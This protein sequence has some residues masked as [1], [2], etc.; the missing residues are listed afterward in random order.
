MS[1]IETGVARVLGAHGWQS[2]ALQVAVF[3]L[4]SAAVF[5]LELRPAHQVNL[6]LQRQIGRRENLL[7]SQVLK[8]MHT[9]DEDSM[10]LLQ[11]NR[12]QQLTDDPGAFTSFMDDGAGHIAW[13]SHTEGVPGT[14]QGAVRR[15]LTLTTDFAGLLRVLN[16]LA[17]PAA[18]M[19]IDSLTASAHQGRLQIT[20][21]V[22][23]PPSAARSVPTAEG[24]P[25]E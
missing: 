24:L 23:M 10:A 7:A 20:M 8:P 5:L 3:L 6:Q 14:A 16:N 21:T 25:Y 15:T 2:P 11:G 1:V 18:C 9:A 22:L 13:R 17:G 19:A 4:L 12:C